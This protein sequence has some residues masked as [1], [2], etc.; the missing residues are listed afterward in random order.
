MMKRSIVTTD[1]AVC[2][3][4][5]PSSRTSLVGI[6]H[7]A[8][9]IRPG[10]R[11]VTVLVVAPAQ[12]L[13]QIEHGEGQTLL[14]LMDVAEFVQEQFRIRLERGIEKYGV[15]QRDC[16]RGTL[17]EEP[18]RHANRNPTAS[19]LHALELRKPVGDLAG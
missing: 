18:S 16:R 14:K 2:L 3:T 13:P 10:I 1:V 5:L 19:P 12:T 11:F 17:P 7:A 9:G 15:P 4:T 8:G 6:A